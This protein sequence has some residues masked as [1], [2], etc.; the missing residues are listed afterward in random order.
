MARALDLSH[1]AVSAHHAEQ[2]GKEKKRSKDEVEKDLSKIC[3]KKLA[4]KWCVDP[5][6]ISTETTG[7]EWFEAGQKISDTEPHRMFFLSMEYVCTS[8]YFNHKELQVEPAIVIGQ[9]GASFHRQV[10]ESTSKVWA[11]SGADL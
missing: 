11:V 1:P 9:A 2:K 6:W 3:A 10:C 4:C 5:G 7:R 8:M